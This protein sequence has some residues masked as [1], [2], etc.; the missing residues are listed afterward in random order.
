MTVRIIEEK[1]GNGRRPFGEYPLE[2]PARDRVANAIVVV[3]VKDA[4]SLQRAL[5]HDVLVVRYQRARH[6]QLDL[7]ALPLQLPSNRDRA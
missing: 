4:Q 6:A 2:Q 3:R 5:E 1:S 7:V